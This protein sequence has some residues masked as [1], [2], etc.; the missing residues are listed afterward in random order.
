MNHD[1]TP[2]GIETATPD[3]D[4]IQ[5]RQELSRLKGEKEFYGLLHELA[6]L[7]YFKNVML[8]C[9]ANNMPMPFYFNPAPPVES[10]A[11]GI[12]VR[13][14]WQ[15]GEHMVATGNSFAAPHI[16]GLA[17]RILSKHPGLTVFQMKAVL[18]ALA[19][20]IAPSGEA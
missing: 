19:A 6:D 3:I 17:T 14:A 7:A 11:F 5:T 8:V 2:E 20:N 9:A 13:V 4:L 1:E 12:N 18:R 15:D 10:G 16:A